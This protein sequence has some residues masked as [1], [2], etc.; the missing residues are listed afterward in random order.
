MQAG[1]RLRI[2]ASMHPQQQQQPDPGTP[3]PPN[4]AQLTTLA[5]LGN[6]A[7]L[8]TAAAAAAPQPPAAVAEAPRGP[9]QPG[10]S[11]HSLAAS[12]LAAAAAAAAAALFG[13]SRGG[14]GN[15]CPPPAPAVAGNA[16][17]IPPVNV[18]ASPEPSLSH[19]LTNT[20]NITPTAFSFRPQP[21]LPLSFFSGGGSGSGSGGASGGSVGLVTGLPQGPPPGSPKAAVRKSGSGSMPGTPRGASGRGLKPQQQQQQLQQQQQQQKQQQQRA[22]TPEQKV[23][24]ILERQG[25]SFCEELG[26]PLHE[27]KLHEGLWQWLCASVLFSAR[28]RSSAA[29]GACKA[30]L[31]QTLRSPEALRRVGQEDCCALLRDSGYDR[32]DEKTANFLVEDARL[33][34]AEYQ[35]DLSRLRE[36]AQRDPSQER[37]LLKKFRGIGDGGVD[38]FFREAQL[39]WEEL[40]PF[41]DKKALKAARMVGLREHPQTLAELC[42]R[43]RQKYVRLI[44][45]LVRIEHSKAY[46]DF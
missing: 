39:V 33:V 31:A 7:G 21:V 6:A 19:L 20:T 23:E 1:K 38:I 37:A 32:Y 41:A 22:M 25:Q 34:L 42:G 44:A 14:G 12:S 17:A 13:G 24:R 30:L 3:L 4:A 43:D 2:E 18:T 8:H 27:G 16:T 5:P 11:A 10:P 35:G 9:P 29:L 36:K 28:I 15:L 26:I 45:A 46:T 40:F